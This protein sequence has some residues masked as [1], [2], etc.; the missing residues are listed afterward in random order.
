MGGRLP[1]LQRL[2]CAVAVAGKRAQVPS[3]QRIWSLPL[4]PSLVGHNCAVVRRSTRRGWPGPWPGPYVEGGHAEASA[5]AHD[6]STA[7]AVRRVRHAVAIGAQMD[8]V[9][10][11][12][13]GSVQ[14]L[15]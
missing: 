11:A 6:T 5:V 8:G 15:Q 1:H 3:A 4:H 14:Q 2:A 7:A 12:K 9:A 10:W 13:V